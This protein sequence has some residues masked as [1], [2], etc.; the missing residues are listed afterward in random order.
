M[1]GAQSYKNPASSE[2]GVLEAMAVSE[3]PVLVAVAF[4]DEAAA[5][6]TWAYDYADCVGA[7]LEILHVIH[8]P[9]DAPGTYRQNGND[10]LE[11]ISDV[12]KRRLDTFVAE[13]A[14][15]RPSQTG[16]DAI[17]SHCV[18]GLPVP[19]IIAVAKQRGARLLV[20]GNRRRN[21]VA[22]LMHASTSQQVAGRAPF[23]V[24]IVKADDQ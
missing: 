22:R 12:A 8:D 17:K 13:V 15:G 10:P 4:T 11:P 6:L 23:P 7:P 19:T 21:G 14:T 3:G 9:A 2:A 20:L 5:A 16:G 18:E 24:T 1:D